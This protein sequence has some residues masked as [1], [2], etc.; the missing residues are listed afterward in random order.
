MNESNFKTL[1]V[2][3][4]LGET[5]FPQIKSFGSRYKAAYGIVYCAESKA[6]RPRVKAPDLDID[7]A[8]IDR[9]Q[10]ELDELIELPID[11]EIAGSAQWKEGVI[12]PC[13]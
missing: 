10:K 2:A 12:V 3:F 6:E 9:M 8:E 13:H 5:R 4:P 1:M 7:Q 11:Q